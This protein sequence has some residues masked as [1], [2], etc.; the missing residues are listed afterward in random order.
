MNV[1]LCCLIFKLP[2]CNVRVVT[3]ACKLVLV[4]ALWSSS[5]N[6]TVPNINNLKFLGWVN[7]CSCVYILIAVLICSCSVADTQMRATG[8]CVIIIQWLL[9][10]FPPFPR[11]SIL[12]TVWLIYRFMGLKPATVMDKYTSLGYFQWRCERHFYLFIFDQIWPSR[13]LVAF[14]SRTIF[15]HCFHLRWEIGKRQHFGI[16]SLNRCLS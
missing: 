10:G 9:S 13:N 7:L 3:V 1:I 12:Y 11:F 6:R 16:Y 2:S 4:V 5:R 8:C 14:K 15:S